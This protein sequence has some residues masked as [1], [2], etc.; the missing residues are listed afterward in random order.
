M[1]KI[2]VWKHHQIIFDN[3]E[4][5]GIPDQGL[6]L[7]F[8][9]QKY[10]GLFP[11]F[12]DFRVNTEKKTDKSEGKIKLRCHLCACL[13]DHAIL[14]LEYIK[15]INQLVSSFGVHGK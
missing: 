6:K 7:K 10:F 14:D 1:V 8:K 4:D 12:Q 15:W 5:S 9:G 3:H 13:K 2:N 11:E